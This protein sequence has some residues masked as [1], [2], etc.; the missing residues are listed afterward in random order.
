M[1]VFVPVGKRIVNFTLLC[2][3]FLALPFGGILLGKALAIFL[4]LR[5]PLS[6]RGS[7][8]FSACILQILAENLNFP[9]NSFDLATIAEE[10]K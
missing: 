6:S 3:L 1:L 7:S 10:K 9:G 2:L 5:V 4:F 8:N